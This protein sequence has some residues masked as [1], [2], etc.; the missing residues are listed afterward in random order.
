MSEEDDTAWPLIESITSPSDRPAW[1]A[2]D[3]GRVP[4]TVTPELSCSPP[5]MNELPD[6]PSSTPRKPV[7]P[8]CTVLEALP[9]SIWPAMAKALLIGIEKACVWDCP[10]EDGDWLDGHCSEGDWL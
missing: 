5:G 2:G 1:A 7:A 4:A 3:P 9:A 8:M 10:D 6:D